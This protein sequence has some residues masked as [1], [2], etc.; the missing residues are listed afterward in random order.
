MRP[1][2]GPPPAGM[3]SLVR[4]LLPPPQPSQTVDGGVASSSGWG[5]GHT[6]PRR[7][8]SKSAAVALDSST[9]GRS[10]RS[11][12][13]PAG[14][15]PARSPR[16]PTA[17]AVRRAA[18]GAWARRRAV[19]AP[20]RTPARPGRLCRGGS[21]CPPSAEKAAVGLP[22][23]RAGP[24]PRVE[25]H[26]RW[27]PPGPWRTGRIGGGVGP[28]PAQ[29]ADVLAGRRAAVDLSRAEPAP[30]GAPMQTRRRPG[31][32]TSKEDP[33]PR[34]P[35]RH[36]PT[37]GPD[38][39]AG[40]VARFLSRPAAASRRGGGS[41]RRGS[42]SRARQ[43]PLEPGGG[44]RRPGPVPGALRQASTAAC[45]QPAT[46]RSVEGRGRSQPRRTAGR[47]R[48]RGRAARRP[49][50]GAPVAGHPSA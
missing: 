1:F 42:S 45:P 23:T 15:G 21:E 35:P 36:P 29:V 18:P 33:G 38:R 44:H 26:G 32:H 43:A 22:A 48:P 41:A 49:G 30:P 6:P 24:P 40:P 14:A 17:S 27:T 16:R 3:A 28:G 5:P 9:A 39:A 34:L 8:C 47:R 20:G 10:R 13:R 50:V 12:S 31:R 2:P 25:D 4:N 19:R 7:A 46:S 11:G 37:S